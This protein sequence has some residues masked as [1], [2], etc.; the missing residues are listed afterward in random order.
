MI[1]SKIFPSSPAFR[2]R[3]FIQISSMQD[4]GYYQDAV[5]GAP[6]QRRVVLS[7]WFTHTFESSLSAF[8]PRQ[9]SRGAEEGW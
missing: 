2:T 3:G 9:G 8:S 1:C 6:D 5:R 4:A 7:Q